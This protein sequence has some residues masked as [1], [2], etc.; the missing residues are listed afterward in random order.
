MKVVDYN[1]GFTLV[2]LIISISI[3]LVLSAMVLFSLDV[4]SRNGKAKDTKRWEDVTAIAEAVGLYQI[5]NNSLPASIAGA[6]Y[7]DTAQKYVLCSTA[8]S[9]TCDG[10]SRDCL[11][12]DDA[13]F[14]GAYLGGSL[15]VDPEKTD[16]TDTG[17]YIARNG[18]QMLFGACSSYDGTSIEY[19]ARAKVPAVCGNGIIED[20]EVCDDSDALTEGCGTSN[21]AELNTPGT[22]CNSDCTAEVTTAITE[23][24][25]YNTWTNDCQLDS[26]WYTNSDVGGTS[27]CNVTCNVEQSIGVAC[28]ELPPPI[29]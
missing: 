23:L 18:D 7:I 1:K 12:I 19:T 17:Y 6:T 27:W 11:V 10:Q 8:S 28:D 14:L 20:N 26:V 4:T 25:D 29:D 5:D 24:C 21:P 3:F 9:L 22:Y 16:S 2:Q 13:D 15:P